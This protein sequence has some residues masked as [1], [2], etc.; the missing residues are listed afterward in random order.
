[1]RCKIILKL[2]KSIILFIIILL[3]LFITCTENGIECSLTG[4]WNI[5]DLEFDN[6]PIDIDEVEGVLKID[7]NDTYEMDMEY[8]FDNGYK[9]EMND[10]GTLKACSYNKYIQ[11]FSDDDDGSTMMSGD[12]DSLNCRYQLNGSN[13]KIYNDNFTMELI[14]IYQ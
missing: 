6:S 13:L 2:K 3:F 4:K 9:V 11:F 7:Y 14:K 12:K 1:M 5:V 10:Y 8:K